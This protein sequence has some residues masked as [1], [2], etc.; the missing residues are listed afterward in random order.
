MIHSE[1]LPSGYGYIALNTNFLRTLG[2][3]NPP[4][5]FGRAITKFI[6]Q[7]VPGIIIDVR[8]NVGGEDD[9]VP[10]MAG[11]FYTAPD[12]YQY[13]AYRDA[14]TGQFQID[15]E[16]ML[17][18]EPREPHFAGPVII[19]VDNAAV[20]TAEGLPLLI[21]RLPQGQV[22]GIHGTHGSFA[23]GDMGVDDYLLPEDLTFK[24]FAG[25]SLDENKVIQVDAN[26]DGVGG[27]IPD[28]RVPL[29]EETV[30]E[31]YVEGKDVVLE[32]AITTLNE[33]K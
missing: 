5:I 26:A 7:D 14:E 13:V 10:K 6:K 33:M 2:S 1:I 19:L 20:S 22:M 11:Y 31:M 16:Q 25:A 18:V 23:V 27:I 24:F 9:I 3:L 32:M 28:I 15:P 12:V 21:Q 29:T 4:K 17:T 30:R 8:G